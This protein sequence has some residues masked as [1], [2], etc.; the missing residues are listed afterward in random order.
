MY[1]HFDRGY[2]ANIQ[3]HIC[4]ENLDGRQ[5]SFL[6]NQNQ[7]KKISSNLFINK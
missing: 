6:A 1:W 5:R 2:W 3:I 4:Q 7:I